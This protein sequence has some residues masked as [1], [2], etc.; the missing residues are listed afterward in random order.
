[1]DQTPTGIHYKQRWMGSGQ[2]HR[3]GFVHFLSVGKKSS[4]PRIIFNRDSS[5]YKVFPMSIMMISKKKFAKIDP[6]EEKCEHFEVSSE[7]FL[8]FVKIFNA[9]VYGELHSTT[10]RKILCIYNL[11]LR[12]LR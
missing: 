9:S 12:E 2:P 3:T 1:M 4:G 6:V 11:S 5:K 8:R 10:I 7:I